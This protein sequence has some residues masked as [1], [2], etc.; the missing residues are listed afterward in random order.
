MAN[1]RTRIG[2]MG[3]TFNPIHHGHLVTAEEARIQFALDRVVFMPTGN[4]PH[5][6]IGGEVAAEHRYVMT[7]LATAANPF[8]EV[9]RLEIERSDL[10]YTVDTL[11]AMKESYP[12]QTEFYFITGADAILEILEWKDPKGLSSLCKFI[13]ATRPGYSTMKLERSLA[14]LREA[15]EAGYPDV[16]LMHIPALAISSTDLRLRVREGWSTRYLVPETVA[17]YIRKEGFYRD[18]D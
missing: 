9:S 17:G 4:P 16:E 6:Q 12:D 3:G 14:L 18:P 10:S 7:V 5:K 2:I 13:A 11:R 15:E 8:F 1:S